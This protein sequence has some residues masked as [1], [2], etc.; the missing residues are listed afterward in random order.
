MEVE[1]ASVARTFMEAWEFLVTPG[2]GSNIITNF[3]TSY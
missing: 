2:D 1:E 3:S